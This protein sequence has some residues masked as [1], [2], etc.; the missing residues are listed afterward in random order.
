MVWI[1]RARKSRRSEK[2][3]LYSFTEPDSSFTASFDDSGQGLVGGGQL[4]VM[5]QPNVVVLLLLVTE[6]GDRLD[7]LPVLL[8]VD[9]CQYSNLV[10][11]VLSNGGLQ[12]Q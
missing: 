10:V 12:G 2:C 6:L 3:E 8:L 1:S 4:G 7:Q 9:V 11:I 5:V